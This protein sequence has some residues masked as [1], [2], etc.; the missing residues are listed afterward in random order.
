MTRMGGIKRGVS[1]V[2]VVS[3]GLYFALLSFPQVALTVVLASKKGFLFSRST[4]TCFEGS[5]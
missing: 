4:V 3:F 1:K 5:G 2:N